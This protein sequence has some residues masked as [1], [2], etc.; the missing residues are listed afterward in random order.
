MKSILIRAEDKNIWERR[1]PL[2]PEDLAKILQKAP[3]QAFVEKSDKRFFKES[4]YQAVGAKICEGM[5]KGDIILGVKE[6]PKEKLL[7]N[8][9]YLFFS[10]TI[11]GQKDNMPMLKR[12]IDGQS[13]LID[14]EKITDAQ[15]RRL[16]FFGRFA[17]DAG[18]IDILWLM[19]QHWQAR[20]LATP[21]SECKQALNYHSVKEAHD[22]IEQIGQQIK[23]NG[24]PQE[25]NPLI[26]GILGYGNVSKGAQYILQALP[27]EQIDPADLETFYKK[28]NFSPHKVYLT[29]F[30]EEHLVKHRQDKPFE[31]QDY[32]RHPEHYQSV[33]DRYLPY[34]SILVNAIYWDARYP[35]FVT[36]DALARLKSAGKLRLQG[37]ADITCDVN[38]SIECNVKATDSGNPAYLVHP[39]TRS[40]TDGYRGEGIVLLA[41][42]NLPAE[43]PNDASRFFSQQLWP[44]I[45]DIVKADLTKPLNKSG[46]PEEI[47][48]AVIVYN[49]QLTE[50]Y[51][52]LEQYLSG[53]E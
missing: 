29:V 46:L 5:E 41:V 30:K 22:H 17:G 42:D 2:V 12:I 51:Q 45:P 33:F 39:E 27:V 31:L 36:W 21:F 3:T 6:I 14:Y 4:E 34:L 44:F 19:G 13:T 40:I 10:H 9:T 18:A 32:Y 23:Q 25:L 24:L 37:I 11:K 52:Y 47:Q 49:G 16:V 48:R 15:G 1:A 20:G 43:L 7:N 53:L 28:G 50:P 8:K 26:I 38:G 35:R